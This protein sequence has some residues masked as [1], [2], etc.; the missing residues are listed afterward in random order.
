MAVTH[1]VRIEVRVAGS[2]PPELPELARQKVSAVL[3]H[4]G[5]P[6]LTARILLAIA[7]DPAVARPAT[8]S[9]TV[10]V[11]GRLVRAEATADTIRNAIDELAS[12][13]RVRLERVWQGGAGSAS[14][15]H[16]SAGTSAYPDTSAEPVIR[17][18]SVAPG[19]E[20]PAT[21]ARELG[22][23]GYRFYLF[24]D[25]L[26]R[27]DTVIYRSADGYRV[28]SVRPFGAAAVPRTPTAEPAPPGRI[29]VS[30]HAA[31]S[32]SVAEAITRLESLGQP[33]VFFADATTGRGG[34]LYHRS[35][36]D[37][38]LVVPTDAPSTPGAAG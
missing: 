2:V 3:R 14:R 16:P 6:V 17:Q 11:N 9:G 21:A 34:V 30:E 29:A 35:D 8:A 24:T 33:F 20:T 31:P 36:G 26:T 32:L 18:A 23:L 10:S 28:A 7:P 19:P 27:Q 15:R 4:V 1:D 38:G 13:L 22:L 5:E 12:R 37:Y 25:E